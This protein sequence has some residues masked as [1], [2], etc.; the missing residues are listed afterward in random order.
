MKYCDSK[1]KPY[2]CRDIVPI[3]L[4]KKKK[5]NKLGISL[6]FTGVSMLDFTNEFIKQI[7]SA[8]ISNLEE[9]KE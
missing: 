8:I 3:K 9:R 7:S 4:L 1:E 6:T 2:H 5:G